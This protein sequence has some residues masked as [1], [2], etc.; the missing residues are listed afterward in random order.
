MNG[1]KPDQPFEAPW[2]ASA[3]A[4]AVHL[5]EQGH[6]TWSDWSTAFGARREKDGDYWLDW[7]DT[8]SDMVTRDNA[9]ETRALTE[10]VEA[11]RAAYLSTPHGQPVILPDE[12]PQAL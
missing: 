4:L 7:L 11:W 3:F 9:E 12:P 2:Q 8:V 5:S 10:L 1:P 6:F